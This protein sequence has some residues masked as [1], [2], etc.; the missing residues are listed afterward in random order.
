MLLLPGLHLPNAG[1]QAWSGNGAPSSTAL[2]VSTVCSLVVGNEMLNSL[3]RRDLLCV[4][5]GIPS[6]T[7]VC[8]VGHDR[9]CH[10]RFR[11]PGG[12]WQCYCY[13]APLQASVRVS[14]AVLPRC[15]S[16]TGAT[17]LSQA[18]AR[19][20]CQLHVKICDR[21][22][23]CADAEATYP[24]MLGFSSLQSTLSFCC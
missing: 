11:H 3:H 1:C 8:S 15:K 10:H 14:P 18:Y 2:Q 16:L 9:D 19:T 13:S 22:D 12:H 21:A 5:T 7:T 23:A 4:Q 20:Y 17:L 24:C 6:I